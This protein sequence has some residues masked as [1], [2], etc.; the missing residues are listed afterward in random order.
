M[1]YTPLLR[2]AGVCM[3]KV[4]AAFFAK[5]MTSKCHK[6]VVIVKNVKWAF[7]GVNCQGLF[8]FNNNRKI[9]VKG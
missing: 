3:F 9:R 5:N 8:H 6:T 2:N 1:F 4:W 7:Q